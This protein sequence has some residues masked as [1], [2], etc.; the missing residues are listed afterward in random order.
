MC[1]WILFADAKSCPLLKEYA[2]SYFL[3]HTPE[4]LESD[5]SIELRDSAELMAE[6]VVVL[7]SK[8]RE[9]MTVTELRKELGKRG[10]D[11]DGSKKAL[12]SRLEDAMR[13]RTED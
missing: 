11:V 12:V 9:S 4:I 1:D 3:L 13:Q 8:N 6:L 5:L 10:L 2:I 7:T